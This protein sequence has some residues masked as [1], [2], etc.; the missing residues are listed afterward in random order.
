MTEMRQGIH[1]C[2]FVIGASLKA[3]TLM[4]VP[5]PVLSPDLEG[6][7]ILRTPSHTWV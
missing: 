7:R 5:P 4:V 1:T 6:R 3:A 2:E